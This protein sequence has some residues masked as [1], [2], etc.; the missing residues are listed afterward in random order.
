[1]LTYTHRVVLP[2]EAGYNE[3]PRRRL[4]G[5]HNIQSN[6]DR[7]TADTWWC[8]VVFQ[9]EWKKKLVY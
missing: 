6:S 3:I 7:T 2:S 8:T 1:M 4:N 9:A 5:E